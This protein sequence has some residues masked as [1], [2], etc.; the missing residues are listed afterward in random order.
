[1][2]KV[3]GFLVANNNSFGIQ[4]LRGAKVEDTKAIL[5]NQLKILAVKLSWLGKLD[6]ACCGTTVGQCQAIR[7]IAAKEQLTVNQLAERLFLDKST[8]S[9]TV[10]NLVK[11]DWV[12]RQVDPVDRRQVNLSLTTAGEKV[13]EGIQARNQWYYQQ[14]L[15]LI[16]P[17]K[18]E[19][20]LESLELLIGAL[21]E[22]EPGC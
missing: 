21:S 22:I 16:P 18:R 19:Q 4:L 9:R 3:F 17:A 2:Q 13:L 1:M 7:E 5:E 6:A 20:L 8:M 11:Q 15:D 10:E 12:S 14:V